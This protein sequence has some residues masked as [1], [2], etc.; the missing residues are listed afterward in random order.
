MSKPATSLQ[1][2]LQ[3]V[4]NMILGTGL[5]STD[6]RDLLLYHTFRQTIKTF[7]D[8]FLQLKGQF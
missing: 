4:D 5:A 8:Q 7:E 1:P 6:L 3:E 2:G